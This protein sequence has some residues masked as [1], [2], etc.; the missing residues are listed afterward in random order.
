MKYI[1]FGTPRFAEIVLEG[2]ADA[3][4][5]P[6]AIVCNPDRPVGRTHVITPPPT[7][8]LAIKISP[9]IDIIQPEKIDET[10][11]KRLQALEPDFAIVAAYAKILPESVLKI[12]RLGTLGVHPSLLPKFRGPSPIQSTILAG[13]PETGTTI[14]V[15]DE[16]T[17][18]GPILAQGK[19][20][21]LPAATYPELE[22]VLAKLGAKLLTQTIPDFLA[23]KTTP[24]P[25][26]ESEATHT[27][28]FKTEDGF[29]SPE[30]LEQPDKALAMLR[31]INALN[32]EPGVWTM[33]QG[34]RVKLL[35]AEMTADMTLRLL[36]TQKEG[37]RPKR[38]ASTDR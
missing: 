28:K 23:Q 1:F 18:H 31:K 13:D 5:L 8:L 11:L 10:F 17:D 29:V 34:K 22:E 19:I 33:L 27:K 32:P 36:E 20:P 38:T 4:M 3:G 24:Q 14:Y 30:E 21:L 35:A 37:E 16:K 15:M 26:D 12:P 2:L 25:Q 9:D 7:K 6:A